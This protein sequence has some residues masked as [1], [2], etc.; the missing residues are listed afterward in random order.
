MTSRQVRNAW[1]QRGIVKLSRMGL[2]HLQHARFTTGLES[3]IFEV[4]QPSFR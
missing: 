3:I 1:S 2:T 4:G